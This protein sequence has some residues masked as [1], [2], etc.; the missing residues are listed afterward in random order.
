M[1]AV[2]QIM[3]RVKT[4]PTLPTAVARLA[5]LLADERSSA[6][7]FEAVMRPDPALTANLLRLANAVL[8]RPVDEV[9]SVRQA[10]VRLG[11]RRVFDLAAGAGFARSLPNFL[12]GYRLSAAEFWRHCVAVASLGERLAATLRLPASDFV[13]TAGL[14]HDVGKLAVGAFLEEDFAALRPLLDEEPITFFEA[15][16]TVLGADHA[17]IGARL[18][19]AWGLPAAIAA[20]SRWHHAPDNAPSEAPQQLIDLIHVA[21]NLAHSL[22]FGS[23]VGE[24]RRAESP[25]A[26]V[27]LGLTVRAIE[28]AAA[29][30]APAVQQLC[31]DAI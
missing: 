25:D 10:I 8:V 16:Q 12:P 6:A 20:A 29:D 19:A 28:E 11:L 31:A 26:V 7:E 24:L 17:E 22:G 27:R 4:L 13:F 2:E 15:E 23:D 3:K 9:A 30:A 5:Q 14:L 21:D 18:A 1:S